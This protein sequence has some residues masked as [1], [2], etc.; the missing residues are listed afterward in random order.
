MLQAC[1]FLYLTDECY[2]ALAHCAGSAS[3]S[4]SQASQTETNGLNNFD[5]GSER[6]SCVR[7]LVARFFGMAAD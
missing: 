2:K 5:T 6:Y 1:A 4:D 3:I 7:F